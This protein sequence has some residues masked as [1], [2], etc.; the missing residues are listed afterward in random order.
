M[1]TKILRAEDFKDDVYISK[2]FAEEERVYELAKKKLSHVTK[3]KPLT[4]NYAQMA[5][6][7]EETNS[8]NSETREKQIE[9]WKRSVTIT[10]KSIQKHVGFVVRSQENHDKLVSYYIAKIIKKKQSE[11]KTAIL[12]NLRYNEFVPYLKYGK[13]NNRGFTKLAERGVYGFILEK[14]KDE[15][16]I[17]IAYIGS[18]ITS[19]AQRF[20]MHKRS[21]SDA[22]QLLDKGAHIEF[23]YIAKDTDTKEFIRQK[24]AQ[25]YT[26]YEDNGFQLI[27]KEFPA[28]HSSL[29]FKPNK[30][31]EKKKEKKEK[32]QKI[33]KTQKAEKVNSNTLSPETK[34]IFQFKT[35]KIKARGSDTLRIINLL[36]ELGMEYNK[37]KNWWINPKE[38]EQ[39]YQNV[40]SKE[41]TNKEKIEDK[42]IKNKNKFVELEENDDE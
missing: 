29:K 24:E 26:L 33:E 3:R 21:N 28:Y 15:E 11:H 1:E 2:L 30:K 36:E 23:L 19:F 6:L 4:L 31:F 41:E 35:I 10:R 42:E 5:E 14:I 7:F 22:Y 8:K 40:I 20:K 38:Y 39:V 16:E 32:I 18:T 12:E 9:K 27:N 25:I 37:K 34:A 13:N 17:K